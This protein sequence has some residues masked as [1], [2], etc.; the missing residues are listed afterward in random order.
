MLYLKEPLSTYERER[1][2]VYEEMINYSILGYVRMSSGLEELTR[3]SKFARYLDLSAPFQ[4]DAAT[5]FHDYCHMNAAGYRI[6]SAR[7]ADVAADMLAAR[8][9]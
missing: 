6:V 8:P 9:K 4:G 7:I 5:Y 1:L 3:G 2:A